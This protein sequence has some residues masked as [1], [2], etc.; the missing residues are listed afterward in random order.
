MKHTIYKRMKGGYLHMITYV[1]EELIS[2]Y[3][4]CHLIPHIMIGYPRL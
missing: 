4:I 2:T 1:S 3:I